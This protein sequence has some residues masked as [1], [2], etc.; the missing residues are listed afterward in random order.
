MQ[1]GLLY[2]RTHLICGVLK[3]HINVQPI[4]R[5]IVSLEVIKKVFTIQGVHRRMSCI[6]VAS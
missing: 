6:H 1:T 4:T 2:P 3:F 5:K